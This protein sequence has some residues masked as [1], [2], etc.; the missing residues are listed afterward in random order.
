MA[1]NTFL[2]SCC[3]RAITFGE[4]GAPPA[5]TSAFALWPVDEALQHLPPNGVIITRGTLHARS[6]NA[7]IS[8]SSRTVDMIARTAFT[9]TF[10]V[11]LDNRGQKAPHLVLHRAAWQLRFDRIFHSKPVAH[12]PSTSRACV[13]NTCGAKGKRTEQ[14]QVSECTGAARRTSV[15]CFAMMIALT[16][17]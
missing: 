5:S 2:C 9:L 7:V 8:A 14:T 6:R 13:L 4:S 12:Q 17:R 16:P 1:L 15:T 3:Q 11:D 10:P